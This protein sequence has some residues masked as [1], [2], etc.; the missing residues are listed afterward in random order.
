[1]IISH[2]PQNKTTMSQLDLNIGIIEL[3][4]MEFYAYHGCFKEE[5][6]VGNKFRINISFA[7]DCSTARLTD[8]IADTVNYV[9][10]YDIAK[11]EMA[12]VSHLVEHVAGRI[13]TAIK[14]E[15]PQ[16]GQLTIKVSK[17]NPPVG[18]QMKQVSVTLRG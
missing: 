3:E 4:E 9:R 6:M 16:I 13:L 15:F 10:I 1:M 18:G 14:Q 7:A 11:R 12:Q 5:Q 2:H 17:V 8:N